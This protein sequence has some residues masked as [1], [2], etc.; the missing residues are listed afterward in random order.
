[1]EGSVELDDD[2]DVDTYFGMLQSS[3]IVG[4]SIAMPIFANLVSGLEL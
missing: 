3:F 2:C 4:L 1:M